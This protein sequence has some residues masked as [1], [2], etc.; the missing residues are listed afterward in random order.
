MT[1]TD[2]TGLVKRSVIRLSNLE[3]SAL[4][5]KKSRLE[6]RQA[7]LK[8]QADRNE[9]ELK[10]VVGAIQYKTNPDMFASQVAKK[11]KVTKPEEEEEEAPAGAAEV[12]APTVAAK[13]KKERKKVPKVEV[14]EEPDDDDDEEEA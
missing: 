9:A 8:S 11:R 2:T 3:D 1:T 13:P 4:E 7:T 10:Q 12:E 5:E 14:V 6:K